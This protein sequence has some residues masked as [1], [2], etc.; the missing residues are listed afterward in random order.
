MSSSFSLEDPMGP[1][2]TFFDSTLWS[3]LA[4]W[5]FMVGNV[6]TRNNKP[7]TEYM[8]PSLLCLTECLWF[9]IRT[10]I[11]Y[12]YDVAGTLLHGV[13]RCD[14]NEVLPLHGT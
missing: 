9:V 3:P 10:L 4:D 13:I 8:S 14:G 5:P 12:A 6:P 11:P 7:I 1:F 2:K